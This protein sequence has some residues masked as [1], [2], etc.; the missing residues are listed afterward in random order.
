MIIDGNVIVPDS[1]MVLTNGEIYSHKVYLGIHD[2]PENWQEIPEEDEP[3]EL[4][5]AEALDIIMG[6]DADESDDSA[7]NP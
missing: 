5:D 7:Q 1:G 4:T 6:R 2:S 3:D